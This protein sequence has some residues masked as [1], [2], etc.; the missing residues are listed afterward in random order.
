MNPEESSVNPTCEEQ[1]LLAERE[2]SAFITAVTRLFGPDQARLSADDWLDEFESMD[3]SSR[4]TGRD[5]RAV[6]IAASAKL[7]NRLAVTLHHRRSPRPS[8]FASTGSEVSPIPS[9]NCLESTLLV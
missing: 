1:V 8:P 6:T 5:W 9:S 2:L 7:A 4:P 3:S